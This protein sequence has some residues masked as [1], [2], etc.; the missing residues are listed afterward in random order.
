MK[1]KLRR[2]LD[3]ELLSE[4]FNRIIYI[5]IYIYTNICMEYCICSV[6]RYFFLF[7]KGRCEKIVKTERFTSKH[8]KQTNN[9]DNNINHNN[10]KTT[11]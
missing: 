11:Q 2:Y 6:Q 1:K 9:N 8:K 4:L 3:E 7:Y 10:W 5:Y